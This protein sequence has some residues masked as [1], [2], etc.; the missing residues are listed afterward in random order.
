MAAGSGPTAGWLDYSVALSTA[1]VPDD[2]RPRPGHTGALVLETSDIDKD[3]A[4]LSE[5]LR[6]DTV[7]TFDLRHFTV[8]RPSH[9]DALSLLP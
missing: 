3:V 1:L 9:V 2:N 4:A 8:I 7:A 5:R 6:L